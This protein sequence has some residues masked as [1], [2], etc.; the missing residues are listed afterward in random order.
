[1]NSSYVY[2]DRKMMKWIPF[3]ALLEQSE[4]ISDMLHGKTRIEKPVLSPDQYDELNYNL[5]LA[6]SFHLAVIVHYFDDGEIK[7]ETGTISR[8]DTYHKT[9]T[10]SDRDFPIMTIV[11]LELDA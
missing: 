10:V 11:K 4:Y 1:M 2:H 3:N 5:Q 8:T 6:L 7:T 9:I